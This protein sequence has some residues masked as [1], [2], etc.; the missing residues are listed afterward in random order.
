MY[1]PEWWPRLAKELPMTLLGIIDEL[2][3]DTTG[4]SDPLPQYLRDAYQAALQWVISNWKEA[5]QT[6]FEIAL[7]K[8][9]QE[10]L[11]ESIATY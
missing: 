9:I 11:K 4:S 2:H 1:R 3:C 5:N 10:T 8:L 7:F 6:D